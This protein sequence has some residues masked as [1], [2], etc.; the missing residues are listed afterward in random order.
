MVMTQIKIIWS[1]LLPNM[2]LILLWNPF[3]CFSLLNAMC[4]N[5]LISLL[6]WVNV[7]IGP[8]MPFWSHFLTNNWAKWALKTLYFLFY[9][10]R[11]SF[12]FWV[13]FFSFFFLVCYWYVQCCSFWNFF[14]QFNF[15]TFPTQVSDSLFFS[16]ESAISKEMQNI[17]RTDQTTC[18]WDLLSHPIQFYFD[19][20]CSPY[21]M[22]WNLLFIIS[23]IWSH[24]F[25]SVSRLLCSF[26]HNHIFGS[27]WWSCQCDV[28]WCSWMCFILLRRCF[29]CI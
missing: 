25:I 29:F 23:L 2:F 10:I 21:L 20:C 18:F 24:I 19:P 4:M 11:L 13:I 17:T 5:I 27:I 28:M 6:F 22:V 7:E 26:Q 14:F 15:L 8:N 3:L 9:K 1:T 16:V 12:H